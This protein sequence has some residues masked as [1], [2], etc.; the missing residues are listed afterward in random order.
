MSSPEVQ[1]SSSVACWCDRTRAERYDSPGNRAF[2]QS[3]LD[4]L[5]DRAPALSGRGLDLG[6]GTGFST[7][8][9]AARYPGVAW[10]GIDIAEAML[11]LAR[12]KP[13]LAGATFLRAS[14]ESLPFADGSIDV[15]VA[16]FSWHWFGELAGRELRRVLRPGGWLLA[17]VPLRRLSGAAGNR[18]LARA[19]LRGRRHF[20]A[21]TS[22]GLRLEE[23]RSLLPGAVHVARHESQV[24]VETFAC[25]RDMLDVLS[26]RGALA[27]I[28]GEH[29]PDSLE[30]PAP[31]EL[32][33]A[34]A[35]VHL[36]VGRARRS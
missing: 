26:S 14:A 29:P 6:C 16:N 33:W 13:S 32:G 34:Y 2:Y 31:L 17:T 25:A 1:A 12:R 35:V 18:A 8:V 21:R 27:A 22:Q 19:L 28:F 15:A 24:D 4:R 5:L 3:A 36:Q 7:E 30:A 9:L 23:A 20:V 11:D 10:Q